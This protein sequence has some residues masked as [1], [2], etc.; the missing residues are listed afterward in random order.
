ME[1]VEIFFPTEVAN[2]LWDR[3]STHWATLCQWQSLRTSAK[4]Q[5]ITFSSVEGRVKLTQTGYQ[6]ALCMALLLSNLQI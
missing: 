2:F 6:H 4:A 3:E 1:I 5:Q